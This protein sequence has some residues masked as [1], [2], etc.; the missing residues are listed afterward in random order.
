MRFSRGAFVGLVLAAASAAAVESRSSPGVQDQRPDS[1]MVA[2]A[3]PAMV[4]ELRSVEVP[5]FD[6]ML[7]LRVSQSVIA[8]RAV[9]VDSVARGTP[10]F[11]ALYRM[12]NLSD[13]LRTK[14]LT[15]HSTAST[16]WRHAVRYNLHSV[17]ANT[18]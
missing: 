17:G 4:L 15:E 14:R 11:V 6:S 8:A 12:P 1:T 5:S 3:P 9:V 10:Q 16:T 18:G 13:S 2:H 7:V